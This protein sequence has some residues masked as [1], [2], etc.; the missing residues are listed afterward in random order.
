MSKK[1]LSL[2]LSTLVAAS[3]ASFTTAF[4]ANDDPNSSESDQT[5]VVKKD[6]SASPASDSKDGITMKVSSE[7][8]TFDHADSNS[9]NNAEGESK[10]SDDNDS[11]ESNSVKF[12]GSSKRR[13][14]RVRDEGSPKKKRSKS[15]DSS[16]SSSDNSEEEAE[17]LP[18][19][20][21]QPEYKTLEQVLLKKYAECSATDSDF[22]TKTENN[23][24][25]LKN[26]ALPSSCF[27]PYY[28]P[29]GELVMARKPIESFNK[30]FR[31]T[32][33]GK[34]YVMLLPT[35]M[36]VKQSNLSIEEVKERILNPENW[37]FKEVEGP[38][39][40]YNSQY[41]DEGAIQSL[42]EYISVITPRTSE[43]RG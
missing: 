13:R 1:L 14:R 40:T 26:K 32:I 38:L 21:A 12:T 18:P 35:F 5:T 22:S 7:P 11:E 37:E 4:A 8:F 31:M 34:P 19:P 25:V 43:N 16:S 28:K 42:D 24:W 15:S 10:K 17:I 41:R 20:A 39:C 36:M 9:N 23:G 2:T 29:N 30:Y 33:S 6:D 27:G 3:S